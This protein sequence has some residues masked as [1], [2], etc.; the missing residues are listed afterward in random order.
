MEK[1]YSDLKQ[2]RIVRMEKQVFDLLFAKLNS[3]FRNICLCISQKNMYGQCNDNCCNCPSAS[4]YLCCMQ[5]PLMHIDINREERVSTISCIF[6]IMNR[7]SPDNLADIVTLSHFNNALY[8][9]NHRIITCSW[10][11]P[12]SE[13]IHTQ[14]SIITWTVNKCKT[15]SI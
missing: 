1:W 13:Q 10:V 2:N 12:L 5:R 15:P 7:V 9:A 3:Y 11:L 6:P 8:R 4:S 14:D